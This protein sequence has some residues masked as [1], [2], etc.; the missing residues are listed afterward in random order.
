MSKNNIWKH[1]IGYEV[2]YRATFGSNQ[3]IPQG[4]VFVNDS[5]STV[6]LCDDLLALPDNKGQIVRSLEDGYF[7]LQWKD[8]ATLDGSW[9]K[10]GN[11]FKNNVTV[12]AIWN[13]TSFDF[14]S[15]AITFDQGI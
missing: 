9:L 12:A 10:I 2:Y 13:T 8:D 11:E 7:Y 4:V 5:P 3:N 14:S 15:S 6:A 1:K